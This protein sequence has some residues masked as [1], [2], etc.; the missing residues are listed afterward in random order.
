M[1]LLTDWQSRRRQPNKIPGFT[2]IELLAAI[3][4]ALFVFLMG[5]PIFNFLTYE[6]ETW[7]LQDN[8]L[9]SQLEYARG[10]AMRREAPVTVCPSTDGRNCQPNG[11]WSTGWVIFIDSISPALHVSVGDELLHRQKGTDRTQPLVAAMDVIQ[12]QPD[13]SIRLN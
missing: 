9:A 4:S 5:M 13:G 7:L 6:G 11:D 10:E 8:S 12:Y 1:Q 3:A 2:G